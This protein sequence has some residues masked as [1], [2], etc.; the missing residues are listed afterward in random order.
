MMMVNEKVKLLDMLKAG[1]SYVSFANNYGGNEWTVRYIKKDEIKIRN[2]V[3]FSKDTK[4]IV[5]PCNKTIVQMENALSMWISDCQEKKVSFDTNM[6]RTRA[7]TLYD[8]LVPEGKLNEDDG[9]D[10][11]KDDPAPQEK[12]GFVTSKGWFEKFKRR[13]GLRSVPLYGEATSAD[14]EAALCYVEDEFPKLIKEGGYLTE[15]V[16]DMDET[17]LFWK[18]MPSRRF[19]YQDEVKTP[20]FNAHKYRVTLLMCGNAAGFMP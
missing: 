17:G 12:R 18:R 9:E 1:S 20:G 3:T 11:D 16:F 19:L 5:T 15:L 10:N 2:T 6:I 4:R 7:K 14:Q 8:S 13:F